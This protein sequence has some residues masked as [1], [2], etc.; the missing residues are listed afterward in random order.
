[1]LL[2]WD[3]CWVP[4]ID[5]D[6]PAPRRGAVPPPPSLAPDDAPALI[7]VPRMEPPPPSLE[8]MVQS[9]GRPS[10]RRDTGNSWPLWIAVVVVAAVITFYVTR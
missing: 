2:R 1:V 4:G 9:A 8:A 3:R 10:R 6:A 7:E 5:D